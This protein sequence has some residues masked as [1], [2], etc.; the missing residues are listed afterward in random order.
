MQEQSHACSSMQALQAEM[1]VLICLDLVE[2]SNFT[3]AHLPKQGV[4]VGDEEIPAR[5]VLNI[6]TACYVTT[7]IIIRDT[8][9]T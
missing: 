9:P 4:R 6:P 8:L 2:I 1:E 5:S 3:P 7:H